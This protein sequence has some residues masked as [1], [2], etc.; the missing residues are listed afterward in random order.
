MVDFQSRD[1]TRGETADETEDADAPES[2]EAAEEPRDGDEVEGPGFAVVTVGSERTIDA[3]AA[4]D[5]VVEVLGDAGEIVTREVI[6]D[7]F[8][9][10]QSTVGS[11]VDRGDVDLILTVGG[12]GPQPADVT[13]DA[14]DP[15]LE[16]RLPGVGELIRRQCAEE[17]GTAVI[18]TRT[19]GGII[20]GVPVVCLPGEPRLARTATREVVL[21]EAEPLA[22]LAAVGED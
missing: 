12:T 7:R 2:A 17:R 20:E 14:V 3:D 22:Q 18:R 16:K 19:M 10:I 9:G 4:G 5:A 6:D 13:V 11:L 1:T 15:L 8:D 21:P